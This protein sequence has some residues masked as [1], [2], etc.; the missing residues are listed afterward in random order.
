MAPMECN[1]LATLYNT[2]SEEISNLIG[3]EFLM[4]HPEIKFVFKKTETQ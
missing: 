3:A 4:N 2:C 1:S